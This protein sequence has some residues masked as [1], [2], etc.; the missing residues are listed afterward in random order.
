MATVLVCMLF[1]T[2]SVTVKLLPF[3][4]KSEMAVVRRSARGRDA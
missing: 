4:N 1:V 3:D 2:K